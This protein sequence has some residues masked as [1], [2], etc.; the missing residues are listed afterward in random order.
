M[1]VRASVAMVGRVA[2]V[3]SAGAQRVGRVAGG[4]REAGGRRG[5]EAMELGLGEVLWERLE[6]VLCSVEE[7]LALKVRA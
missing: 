7:G 6:D 5:A 4:G 3:V 1:W 2:T